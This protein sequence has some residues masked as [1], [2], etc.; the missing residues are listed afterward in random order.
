MPSFPAFTS[1]AVQLRQG[2]MKREGWE[3][4]TCLNALL[5]LPEPPYHIRLI[6]GGKAKHLNMPF[7]RLPLFQ[8]I[9]VTGRPDMLISLNGR[10]PAQPFQPNIFDNTDYFLNNS[11]KSVYTD[12]GGGGV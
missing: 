2:S 5:S 12:W 11:V 9:C 3:R 4:K 8:T 6:Q 1:S 10:K 7:L